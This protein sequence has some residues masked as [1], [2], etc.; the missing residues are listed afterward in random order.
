MDSFPLG[1]RAVAR[2]GFGAMQLPGPGVFGPPRDRD[3]ALAVLR[4]AVELGVDH[5]DTA[6]FYGPDVA[7]ELICEALHPYPENL[8]LV[9]KVGGRRDDAGGWL[10]V[11]E[12]A[13]LRRDIELNL[14]TLGVDQLAAVN[15]RLFESDGPDRLFDDQLSVMIQVRDEGLIGGIGLSNI[16]REHL[17]RALERTE[18]ACVQNA[19]NLVDRDSAPVLDEC[20]ARGIAFV[21]FFPLGAAFLQP[22]PVLG[23]PSVQRIAE[24][25]G[26]TPAQVALAWTLSVA[27]NVLLIPGTSSVRHLEENLEVASIELD[28]DS[29]EQLTALAG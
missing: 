26:R 22:N 15:L 29:R 2:I 27:P 12:P 20:T 16:N 21:P 25:L 1:G 13:D 23:N 18:I 5:I 10:P 11:A 28:E 17:L 9:T 24:R 6:Q 4:R 19:F 8:A 3:Q 14:L 7:N